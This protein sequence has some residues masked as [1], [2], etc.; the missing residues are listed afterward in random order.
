M[1]LDKFDG[2]NFRRWQKKMHFM[3][4]TL[5]VVYVL[6]KPYPEEKEDETLEET[7]VRMKFE[8]D[9]YIC[10]GHILNALSDAMF[11]VYSNTETAKEMW[12]SLEGRY[13]TEDA[14]SKKF[15]VSQFMS[16]KMVDNKSVIDQL[17]DIQHILNQFKIK[18]MNMDESIVVSS[19]IDKLPPSWKDY[20]KS[21]KH[22]TE[23]LTLE[24]LAVHLTVEEQTRR[25]E[26]EEL[27]A[28]ASKVHVVEE[29]KGSNK[30][31]HKKQKVRRDYDR[32]D[33]P[34]GKKP[35]VE[36]WRCGQPGH[37][38]KDCKSKKKKDPQAS[39]P[40]GKF[41]AVVSE[42]NM[43]GD[44]G[45]WW[46]DS[47]ATK[48]VCIDKRFFTDYEVVDDGSFLYMGNSSTAPI[49][50]KGKVDLEFTS[51][52]VLTLTDVYH[53]PEVRKNLV[54]GSLLDKH[55]FRLVFEANK[56]VL[57][58]NGTF[59]GKG[60]VCEGMYKLN[61]NNTFT[62]SAYLLDSL[63]LWH[64]RLG[65]VNTRKMDMMVKLDLIPK[66][67]VDMVDRCNVCSLTKITRVPFPKI[68]KTTTLLELVH[69]DVCDMHSTPTRGGKQ[70]FVTFIDDYSKYCHVYLLHSKD[71]V[72]EKFI[73]FKTEVENQCG[74]TIKR[75][76]SNRGGEYYF[77][78]YCES[79]GIIH[80][81]TA[82]YTPQQNGVAEWKNRTL[83]E[84]VNAMLSNSGLGTGLWG[85]A[86]L[87]AA[88]I[89][90]R[91][92]LKKSQITP[93]ELWKKKKPNLSYFKT[94]GCR[95]IVRLPKPKRKKLG[96]KG[97]E[98]IFLGYALH[99]KAYRFLV[100][101]PNDSYGVNTIIESRDA[102]FYEN[103]FVPI[104]KEV[105]EENESISY[106]PESE[107]EPTEQV[108]LRRS[109]RARVAKSFGPDFIVYLVEGTRDTTC[110]HTMVSY[111][112]ESDPLTFGEAMKSQD[113]AFW[114]EA[115]QDEMDSIMGNDTWILADLPPGS[116]AIGCK[117]IFKKK[118]KVDGTIDKFK[119]RL[120]AKGFTQKEG[121]DYFDTYAP[122][123]RIS[124][125]RVL[126]AIASIHKLHI[127]QM[128]VKTAFLNGELD[129]EIYMKQPEGFVVQGQEH[130]VC[131]LVK[132][133]YGLKQAPKQWHE[134][135]DKVIVSN[136]FRIHQSD[137]CVYSKF[138][139]TQGVIVCLYVDDMLIFETDLDSIQSTKDMLSSSFSM[140]DMGVADVILGIRITRQGGNIVLS[141]SHYIEKIL[142]K[143]NHFDCTPIA[144][145][146]DPHVKLYPNTGRAVSQLDY[147]RVIGSLM[148]AMTSTRPDIAFAVGKL[149]RYTHNPSDIHWNA[150]NRV[151]RYLKKTIDYGIV[152]SGYPSVLEGYTDAS[153]I[154]E[155]EDHL[156]TS[157]WVFTLGGGAVSWGSKKQSIITD[158]TMAAE[159]VA[160]ASGS[161]EAEWLRSMLWEIPLWPKPMPSVSLHCD[162]QSAL[163]R[164]YS[165]V[166]NGKSRH[167]GLRHS[168]VRNLITDGVITIDYVKSGQNLADPLTKGL[169]R[170]LVWKTSQGM[171]L[172]PTKI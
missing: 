8:N 94:W 168:Y 7:R 82:P 76:R 131:K 57:S 10:K 55:G 123:A 161:K 28:G 2:G 147:S 163:S 132:S 78:D 51:G 73:T 71:E 5:N 21:L 37:F 74:K 126:L 16:Y 90:N 128:D 134:K 159:F 144:T 148:Y 13:M 41:L 38:K 140:K 72:L 79:V 162:S 46:M 136:G 29:G 64:N 143:F 142:K 31:K 65:H 14:T 133:L 4:T 42:I 89:L 84:M 156:S 60:Y 61:V 70:Y 95:A 58:R 112:V 153:W 3:L 125:I 9:D 150:V 22:Q 50:G 167:I 129:E 12:D 27:G 149:S 11:D 135:F 62:V 103:R 1:K 105:N 45:N 166:Y 92:P 40:K 18:N 77:P 56:F 139:E 155:N 122:V 170:D 23:D 152:Y 127:H 124:T 54:S 160:L 19:V 130:K 80:E 101:E 87:T 36:C 67:D 109:K 48:H 107:A 98:C 145:P 47:G 118:M 121:I 102:V 30:G 6:T 115:I 93:Y 164:A 111:H 117:W 141:Q 69:S 91:V 146:Y 66:Y 137:K 17:H 158:S 104:P 157:G 116:K 106:G 138:T 59:V 68:V 44:A 96:E 52:N 108:E 81:K 154:A 53:V 171:G 39:G 15:L 165:Q 63:S 114:K 24:Q 99:S 172:K 86:I 25:Q 49:K 110:N 85:E 119:A 20:K 43:V 75:L 33:D 100:S 169:A 97:I 151:L 88:Y 26:K 35:K 113:C 83:T 34:K 120:V 32:G